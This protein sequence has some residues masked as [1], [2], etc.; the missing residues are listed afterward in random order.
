[1]GID[2]IRI[3]KINKNESGGVKS[4]LSFFA[5]CNSNGN[6]KK[7]GLN[8]LNIQYN[9]LNLTS[10]VS[11]SQGM[12]ARYHWLT[13]GTKTSVFDASGAN[14][15]EYL[16]SLIYKRVNGELQLEGTSF[17]GGRIE[18]SE[19]VD[20]AVYTPNYFIADHLGSTR[21]VVKLTPDG[22]EV[23]ERNDYLPYGGRWEVPGAA[24]S[25][26]RF[27]F[28]GKEDQTIGNLPYQDF[29]ARFYGG[30][31]PIWTT[32]DLLMQFDSGYVYCGNNLIKFFDPTG[33]WSETS[34]G[35]YTDDPADISR[36]VNYMAGSP[37]ANIN[38]MHRFVSSEMSS[39]RAGIYEDRWGAHFLESA[40][41]YGKPGNW[42]PD[43]YS[44]NRIRGFQSDH[45]NGLLDSDYHQRFFNPVIAAVYQGQNNFLIGAVGV[46]GS[47]LSTLGKSLSLIGNIGAASGYGLG[48]SG[49]GSVLSL[50]G[51]GL[52]A[53]HGHLIGNEKQVTGAL[54]DAGIGLIDLGIG[55][56]TMFR[57]GKMTYDA[58]MDAQKGVGAINLF[59]TPGRWLMDYGTNPR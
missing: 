26:N 13:D 38:D 35:Y 12:H 32:P 33:L 3:G 40:K 6:M 47:I 10:I 27:R 51:S 31:L 44:W 7:D 49:V 42:K 25:D 18:V 58:F 1:M 19:S 17:G 50:A 30:K 34:R 55:A 2:R 28:S 52:E 36:L 29:G 53:L 48:L 15:L 45:A 46:S 37:G 57:S 11:S 5:I 20:G 22:L 56:G 16:G 14:G 21:A 54:I 4:S 9:Y 24:I 59:F 43:E 41:I 8:D 39:T 23:L